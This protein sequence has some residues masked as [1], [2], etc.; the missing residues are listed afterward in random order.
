VFAGWLAALVV[1]AWF[2]AGPLMPCPS[3]RVENRSEEL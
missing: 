2:I 1:P 3:A